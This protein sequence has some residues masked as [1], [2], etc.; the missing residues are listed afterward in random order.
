MTVKWSVAVGYD[1]VEEDTGIG[2]EVAAKLL[3][4]VGNYS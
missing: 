4:G 2:V 1:M 3:G